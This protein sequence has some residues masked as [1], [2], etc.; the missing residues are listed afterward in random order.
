M[1]DYNK[2]NSR[3]RTIRIDFEVAQTPTLPL[4]KEGILQFSSTSWSSRFHLYIYTVSIISKHAEVCLY[5]FVLFECMREYILVTY[6][7]LL[8]MEYFHTWLRDPGWEH[9][10]DHLLPIHLIYWWGT[11]IL[12]WELEQVEVLVQ[13]HSHLIH[14]RLICWLDFSHTWLST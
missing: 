13:S 6:M 12:G 3:R 1:Y 2:F 5:E 7:S 10:H 4:N 14:V 11:L 9:M 8:P